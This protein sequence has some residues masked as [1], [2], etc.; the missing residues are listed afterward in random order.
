MLK[1]NINDHCRQIVEH[2][3]FFIIMTELLSRQ[4]INSNYAITRDKNT[5]EFISCATIITNWHDRL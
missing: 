1:L 5:E 3:C 2:S 4:I